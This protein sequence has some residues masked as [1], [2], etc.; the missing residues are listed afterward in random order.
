MVSRRRE[1]AK[2][3]EDNVDTQINGD[4][5]REQESTDAENLQNAEYEKEKT[6]FINKIKSQIN[7][8]SMTKK[9]R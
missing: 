9:N 2:A 6:A 5:K 8:K 7:V 3:K 1:E 4:V